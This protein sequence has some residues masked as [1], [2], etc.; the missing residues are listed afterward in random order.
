MPEQDVETA[1]GLV[2]DSLLGK[3]VANHELCQNVMALTGMICLE[4][5][6]IRASKVNI[7][8]VEMSG[9]R[10]IAKVDIILRGKPAVQL[11]DVPGKDTLLTHI[12]AE[13][14]LFY[15][16][17]RVHPAL[18][19]WIRQVIEKMETY[20]LQHGK[21]YADLGFTK[22][23]VDHESNIVLDLAV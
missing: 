4:M 9:Q 13:N 11:P 15:E 5:D 18:V 23:I 16:F 17:L 1:I 20:A 7:G 2:S 3:L 10:L 22:A 14:K 8:P 21:R 6:G 19:T 12:G